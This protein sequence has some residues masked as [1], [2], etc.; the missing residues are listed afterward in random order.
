[1]GK[2]KEKKTYFEYYNFDSKDKNAKE[3]IEKALEIALDTRKFEIELYW[4]R[5]NYFWLF[6]ASIF[7]AWNA[8]LDRV[9]D[10]FVVMGLGLIVSF[11]WFCVNR[12]SKFWQENWEN[13]VYELT[14]KLGY[15][16]FNIIKQY[17][18]KAHYLR[19]NYPYSVSKVNQCVSLFTVIAWICLIFI[20]LNNVICNLSN[21]CV[22]KYLFLNLIA[23]LCICFIIFIIHWF[24]K[25]FAAE[26]PKY[27]GEEWEEKTE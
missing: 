6:V 8:T 25:S 3:K 7:V 2:D 19:S 1:M 26:N 22:Y 24:S 15:P 16:I 11:A 9:V 13:H 21:P 4:K 27:F 18:T 12:G 20:R 10:N 23:L 17:N 14:K 5:A